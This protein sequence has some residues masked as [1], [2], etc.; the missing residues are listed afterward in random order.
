MVFTDTNYDFGN[1][2]EGEKVTHVF[3]YKNYGNG[4]LVISNAISQLRMHQ[5]FLCPE[6]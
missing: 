1:I 4:D 6:G 5:T 2:K 3:I